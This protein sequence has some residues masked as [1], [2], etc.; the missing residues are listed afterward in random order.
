MSVLELR[1][2]VREQ[3]AALVG[4]VADAA[5]AHELDD[6]TAA[7]SSSPGLR[8]SPDD[9]VVTTDC[10]H[11]G[12]LLPLA[13]L[14]SDRARRRSRRPA[15]GRGVRRILPAIGPRTRAARAL[16][17][18]LDDRPGDAGARAQARDEVCRCSWTAR[19]RSA[20]SPST[21]ASSTTTPSPG[22][23]GCAG[24]SRSGAL[25]VRDPEALGIASPAYF[26]QTSLEPDGSVRTDRKEQRASTR[27]GWPRRALAGL[28]PR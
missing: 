1:D 9:E 7:T 27:V 19:S 5:R 3:L 6:A 23:S 17:R 8:L 15:R 21:S 2:R 28:R 25:Y 14:G 13:R 12:L 18:S 22:R 11:P 20:R 10:E 24:R 16:T 26:A 4:A